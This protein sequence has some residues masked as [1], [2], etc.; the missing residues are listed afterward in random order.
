MLTNVKDQGGKGPNSR[1]LRTLTVRLQ[2]YPTPRAFLICPVVYRTLPLPAH[3]LHLRSARVAELSSP[4]QLCPGL[5]LWP[6]GCL[7]P[8]TIA[9]PLVPCP[10]LPGRLCGPFA[11]LR[12]CMSLRPAGVSDMSTCS[13]LPACWALL[14]PSCLHADL[15]LHRIHSQ[16]VPWREPANPRQSFEAVR[17][18]SSLQSAPLAACSTRAYVFSR[19]R[20]ACERW[21]C[22]PPSCSS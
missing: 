11:T 15:R 6:R 9:T 1:C 16:P 13:M 18:P 4:T 21:P 7:S 12:P 3:C 10:T 8:R 17:L 22:A 5:F 19:F 2:V 14:V 20:A